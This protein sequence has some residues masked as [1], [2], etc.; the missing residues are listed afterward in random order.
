M[1]GGCLALVICVASI[2][3]SLIFQQVHCALCGHRMQETRRF[4][5]KSSGG[6]VFYDCPNCGYGVL[7]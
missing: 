2:L 4:Q 7:R 3:H 1:V 5:E 6:V